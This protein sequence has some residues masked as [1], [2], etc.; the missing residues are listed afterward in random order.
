MCEDKSVLK[1]ERK[2]AKRMRLKIVGVGNTM[3]SYS[4][5]YLRAPK[6]RTEKR[7]NQPYNRNTKPN[8]TQS[9]RTFSEIRNETKKPEITVSQIDKDM[10]KKMKQKKEKDDS[11]DDSQGD[12]PLNYDFDLLDLSMDGGNNFKKKK[13]PTNDEEPDFL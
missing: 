7:S 8:Y 4:D 13:K 2:R 12:E 6:N 1:E 5:K 9:Q 3:A 10:E 11:D